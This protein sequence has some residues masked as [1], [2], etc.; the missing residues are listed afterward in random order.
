MAETG[1]SPQNGPR[2]SENRRRVSAWTAM[3]E[4]V[5][6]GVIAGLVVALIGWAAGEVV[7]HA[8]VEVAK[9][10]NGYSLEVGWED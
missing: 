2:R 4:D 7:D 1:K 8:T 6:A 9:T 3:R 10:E 5:V